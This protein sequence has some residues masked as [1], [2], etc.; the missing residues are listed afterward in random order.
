SVQVVGFN[1]ESG[2]GRPWNLVEG[3]VEDLKIPDAII[4]DELYKEKLGVTRVGEM[5]EIGGH[6]ARVV[7][8]TRGIRAFTTSPYVFTSFKNAQS[9][10][11]MREDQTYFVLVKLAPGANPEQVRQGILQ[12]VTDVQVL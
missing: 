9:F 2:M 1:L 5:F 11:N 3:R 4:V 12:Q 7:G 6:R 8:F 10:N